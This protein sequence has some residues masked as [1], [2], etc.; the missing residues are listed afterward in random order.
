MCGCGPLCRQGPV[1]S[2]AF[3]DLIDMSR[4][5]RPRQDQMICTYSCEE[6]SY[7]TGHC[8]ELRYVYAPF[9]CSPMNCRVCRGG[10]YAPFYVDIHFCDV[11]CDASNSSRVKC[12]F[13]YLAELFLLAI[14]GRHNSELCVCK[15]YVT[16][17]TAVYKMHPLCSVCLWTTCILRTFLRVQFVLLCLKW[18]F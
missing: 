17:S 5:Q 15:H 18:C 1:L 3:S 6:K 11:T 4:L 16:K 2:S 7:I 9:V 10:S 12:M 13:K 14:Q 8:Y